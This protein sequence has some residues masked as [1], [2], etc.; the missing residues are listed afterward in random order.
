MS[1]N[2]LEVAEVFVKGLG[3]KERAENLDELG[4]T[5]MVSV[6]YIEL[7][8]DGN[9]HGTGVEDMPSENFSEIAKSDF[10]EIITYGDTP[11]N[12]TKKVVETIRIN[13]LGG[14]RKDME[15]Y[16]LKKLDKDVVNVEVRYF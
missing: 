9:I 14:N 5:T 2:Y 12:S 1:R 3:W 15:K 7:D 4:R 8:S 10:M 11:R 16:V 6:S 13:F